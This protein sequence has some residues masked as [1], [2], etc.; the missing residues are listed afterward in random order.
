MLNLDILCKKFASVSALQVARRAEAGSPQ[1]LHDHYTQKLVLNPGQAGYTVTDEF[2]FFG[3][4]LERESGQLL[5][6]GPATEHPLTADAKL[7]VASQLGLRGK[8]AAALIGKLGAIPIMPLTAFIQ[9]LSFLNYIVNEDETVQS[10]FTENAT[11]LHAHQH[12]SRA[13]SQYHNTEQLEAQML[14]CIEHGNPERLEQLQDAT[15]LNQ[16]TTGVIAKDSIR[17]H[18]NILVT[19]TT[20]AC[21]A[22]IRGGLD[23][24]LSLS[25]SDQ[26]MQQVEGV[27]TFDGFNRLWR[28]MLLDFATRTANLRLPQESSELVRS[29]ARKISSQLYQKIS[30]EQLAKELNVSRSYLSH[31]FKRETGTSLTDYI[32]QQK[33][34]E[35]RRLME[36]T[37]MT[38]AEISY[39]L[40]FSSQSYFNTTFRKVTGQTPG[41]IPRGSKK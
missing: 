14:S 38:L 26:Y 18:R 2:L 1:E 29:A 3:K 6:V 27:Y 40:A 17:A 33:I 4:V 5:L 35:A 11:P 25:L 41:S 37:D 30:V 15:M 12:I 24:D 20:L 16:Y 32:L 10:N 8:Q 31:Q 39:Q 13:P 7:R 36:A 28:Q 23:Y 22:A 21:R 34:S 19:A 9:Q